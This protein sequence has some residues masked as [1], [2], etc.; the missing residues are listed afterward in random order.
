MATAKKLPSGSW[1]VRATK[2]VDGKKTTKSFTAKTAKEAERLADEWQSH[3][4]MIGNDSTT[5]TVEQAINEYINIKSNVLSASTIYAYQKY[6]KNSFDDIKTLPLYKLNNIVIQRSINI[7]AETVSTKTLKNRYGLLTATLKMFYPELTVSVTFPP[8]KPKPKYEFTKEYLAEILNAIKGEPIELPALLAMCLS[9]RASEVA[10]L[11]WSDIDFDNRTATIQR[12]KL[13]TTDG[14][15]IQERTK[16]A[17]STRVIGIPD[18]LYDKLKSA[19]LMAK[20]DYLTDVPPNQYWNMLNR[21]L[22][23]HNVKGLSFHQLRH[24]TASIMLNLGIDNKT[25]QS[26]GGWSTDVV[27]KSVYQHSFEETRKQASK[28]L[29]NYFNNLS[30]NKKVKKYKVKRHIS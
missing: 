29:N 25:A 22:K 9:C 15:I 27:L 5:L 19:K 10:G 13:Y 20:S 3:I 16:T 4:E 24:I 18:I 17:S 28:D 26:I 21:A 23:K 12:A 6:L 30:G 7:S 1:R 8:K 11:K 2:V 14:Y